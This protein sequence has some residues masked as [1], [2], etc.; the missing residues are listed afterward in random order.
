MSID[1][2]SLLEQE[3]HPRIL[4][5]GDVMLDRYLFGN[6]ERISPEAP[7]PVLSIGK[8]EHRLGG[9]SSVATMVATLG[10]RTI[11]ATV[12]GD[13]VEGRVVRELLEKNGIDTRCVLTVH[14]RCTTVKERLL[15]RSQQRYPHQ[16]MRVDR[17]V[18]SPIESDQAEALLDGMA[19]CIGDVDL[20]LVSD[21]NKGVCKGEM[22]QR[23]V[24]LARAAGVPV[25]ADPVKKADYHRYV[26]CTCITPNRLE[27]AMA[28]DMTVE[29]PQDGLDAARRLLQFGVESAIVTLDRDGMAWAD[30]AGNA[31]LVP[32]R[33]RQV[34]DITGA[35]DMVL[36]TLGYALAAGADAVTAIEI[37]NTA[38]GLEVERLGVVPVTRDEILVE[39]GRNSNTA[40]HKIVPIDQIEAHV[41]RLRH[42][43]Q[44]VVMTNGCFDLLHPGHVACL[45]EARRH[46]DCL[47]VAMNSDRSV[48]ELKG[49]GRPIVDEQGRAEMLAALA[50]VDCVVIFDDRSVGGLVERVAPDVLV[51]GGEY[52]VDQIV[53]SE[54]VLDRGGCV[55]PVVMK[56]TYSTSALVDK[57]R[58]LP[59]RKRSAA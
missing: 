16:M 12:V 56:S 23:V 45:Q 40:G 59:L 11:L 1:A 14:D 48:R 7:I 30:N 9:A 38:G 29:T 44:R 15:G 28:T 24:A 34:C 10:A 2:F 52:S 36:A 43:G 25:I 49:A 42:A 54:T 41:R 57:I 19:S 18:T 27:A 35:G 53:G 31:R 33:P 51:K 26:G 21:Y 46:G 58:D 4:L 6:V 3:L 8:Q 32:A 50:C 47:L 39:L 5:V 20:V 17:E 13:D 22:I 37:A 55:V